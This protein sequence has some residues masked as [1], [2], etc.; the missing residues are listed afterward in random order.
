VFIKIND[1]IFFPRVSY[2]AGFVLKYFNGGDV[3]NK[4]VEI[5][6]TGTPVKTK[7]VTWDLTFNFDHFE[8]TVLK[9]NAGPGGYYESDTWVYGNLRTQTSPG[10]S[11]YSLYGTAFAKNDKGQ[12]LIS[13]TTG[14]PVTTSN[15][16]QPFVF[17]GDRAPDFSIG[18]L[19]SLSYKTFTLSFNI[20][21]R[22][23]GDI[24]N[25][26]EM[27]LYRNGLSTRTLDRETPRIIEG[28]LNDGLQNTAN[29][30]PNNIII[31]PYF[32]NDFYQSTAAGGAGFVEA[33]FVEKN[34]KWLRMRDLTLSYKLHADVVKR[35]RIKSASF[36]ITAT[37]LF[38]ITNYAGADPSVNSNTASAGGIGGM[39]IDYGSI[40]APRAI[41][42]GIR[43]SF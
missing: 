5:Q 29:P 13:P 4:G 30:T 32:R 31:T 2:G 9:I 3:Q 34:I 43:I 26:T 15:F 35:F 16:G 11:I 17:V 27:A 23:G 8:N 20:D 21:I 24:F 10:K 18:I 38:L 25:G 7:N 22:K 12:L 39:G 1:Q 14:L 28:V 6:L 19:N 36:F 41:N 40:S 33:D 42:T 37:D